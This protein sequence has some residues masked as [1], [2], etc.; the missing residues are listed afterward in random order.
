MRECCIG[1]SFRVASGIWFSF[2]LYKSMGPNFG[3]RCTICIVKERHTPR[4]KCQSSCFTI[5][6][7]WQIWSGSVKRFQDYL[8]L[9]FS[10]LKFCPQD[11]GRLFLKWSPGSKT[12]KK[13]NI[14][15]FLERNGR[16]HRVLKRII[17]LHEYTSNHFIIVILTVIQE[18]ALKK[19]LP[20]LGR[21]KY[22]L[23]V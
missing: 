18:Y 19:R 15:W 22:S 3:T 11:A 13:H 5:I 4:V 7:N 14:S 8:E 2:S 17:S 21:G 6:P 9:K 10:R 12:H 20:H 16:K 1:I 23:V